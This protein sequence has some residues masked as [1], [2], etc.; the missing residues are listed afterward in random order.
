MEIIIDSVISLIDPDKRVEIYIRLHEKY[1]E[2]ANSFAKK[3]DLVQ[4][5]EKYWEAVTALLNAIGEIKK[6]PH[7]SR[8][9]YSEIIERIAEEV[10]DPSLS[11]LFASAERIHAN[12]YHNFLKKAT[13][14]ELRRNVL[15]LVKKLKNYVSSL[16][17]N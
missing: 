9:D 8:R 15:E 1:L 16:I 12:F 3:G 14:E 17:R 10:N 11:S 2:E 5:C 4:A 7:Y 13:F 6:L